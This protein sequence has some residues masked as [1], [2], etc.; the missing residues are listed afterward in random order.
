MPKVFNKGKKPIIY[1]RT[2]DGHQCIHPGKGLTFG[3]DEA[4]KIIDK[5][6]AAVSEDDY[7]KHLAEIEKQKKEAFDKEAAKQKGKK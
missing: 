1:N 3:T 2:F 4:K 5:F 7:K 6:P